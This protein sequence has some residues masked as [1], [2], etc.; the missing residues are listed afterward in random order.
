MMRERECRLDGG[1]QIG[2]IDRKRWEDVRV[3][4]TYHLGPEAHD[5]ASAILLC[6]ML[7]GCE[8]VPRI[9]RREGGRHEEHLPVPVG[10]D[11]AEAAHGD[12]ERVL[13]R[14]IAVRGQAERLEAAHV[15]VGAA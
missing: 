10:R 11:E 9:A 5:A 14:R 8:D 2:P 6:G 12:V 4:A 3:L 7:D 15:A 13:D 1:G